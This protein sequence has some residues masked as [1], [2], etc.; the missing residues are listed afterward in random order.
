MSRD[1]RLYLEDIVTSC[2]KILRFIADMSRD[3]FLRD[4][5][6][7]DAVVRNLEIIGEAAK[8]IPA[9]VRQKTP[10]IEWRKISGMRDILSHGYF[11]IDE[12]ILWDVVRNKVPGLA[13]EVNK[14]LDEDQ[15]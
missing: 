8:N 5:K 15:V 6:T 9:E 3:A 12:D 2:E 11:G 1:I 14:F 10:N 4:E 7:Y 13:K